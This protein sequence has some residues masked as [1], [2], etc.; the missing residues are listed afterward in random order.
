MN[1]NLIHLTDWFI[2]NKL[3][4]NV[5]KTNYMLFSDA[6]KYLPELQLHINDQ[7]IEKTECATSLGI[8]ID[9]KLKWDVHINKIKSRLSS[10]LYTINKIKKHFAPIKILTTL[11]YS[12]VYPYLI[13]GI[14]QWG[15]TFRTHFNK[16]NI[17]QKKIMRAIVGAKYN[18]YTS[19]IFHHLR[20]VKLED[21][22][23][24]HVTIVGKY[25]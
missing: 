9:D 6:T 18:A 1:Q 10:S 23:K 14:T 5:T 25:L 4:L 8:H 3:S 21:I 15:T 24:L 20:I 17:M 11:Y 22:H 12:M 13:Y 16:L 7:L 19:D 2:G